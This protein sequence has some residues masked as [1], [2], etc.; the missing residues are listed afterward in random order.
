MKRPVLAVARAAVAAAGSSAG[1]RCAAPSGPVTTAV[2]PSLFTGARWAVCLEP[3]TELPRW[4]RVAEVALAV[5]AEVVPGHRRRARRRRRRDQPR[6]A[7]AGRR[8]RRGRRRRRS[9][10]ARPG[11]R[12]L[13]RRHP[14]DRQRPR[15]RHRDGRGQRRP[16]RRALARVLAHL[17]QPWP[18]LVARGHA[19]VTR[20][21]GAGATSGCRWSGPP[22]SPWAAPVA[23]SPGG[24]PRSSRGWV[25]DGVSLFPDG[26]QG[27]IVGHGRDGHPQPHPRARGRGAQAARD[28][29]PHR[30]AA[31]PDRQAR[32]GPGPVLGP[33]APAAGQAPVRREPRRGAG[34][35]PSRRSR[36]TC[37]RSRGPAAS[38]P[39]NA[40]CQS[41]RDRGSVSLRPVTDSIRRS[42]C[43]TV[44][45]WQ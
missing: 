7:P 31:R 29:R 4:L 22:C 44:L 6:P 33:A 1:T 26:P 21:T 40:S 36:A 15:A 45:R 5:G 18:D 16:D 37:S 38:V 9:A 34:S 19:V 42:R 8:A 10:R 17:E 24:W 3:D 41:N 25:P 12:Q 13:P 32:G 30:G 14:R 23:R 43:M 2:D 35:A 28:Q 11:R 27:R 20:Q 39:S